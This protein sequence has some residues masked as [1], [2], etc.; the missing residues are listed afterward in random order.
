MTRCLDQVQNDF[1]SRWGSNHANGTWKV[2][3]NDFL[4]RCSNWVNSSEYGRWKWQNHYMRAL[5][6]QGKVV[7]LMSSSL[8]HD[9]KFSRNDRQTTWFGCVNMRK[10]LWW[11]H[12]HQHYFRILT[13]FIFLNFIHL[14]FLVRVLHN[15]TPWFVRPSVG[16][17]IF[18]HILFYLCFLFLDLNAPAQM[19]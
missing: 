7:T 11:D 6:K 3:G 12:H 9:I 15:S 10:V 18:R 2:L 14:A 17:S 19:L 8:I 1:P 5:R 13:I 16:Q 4:F